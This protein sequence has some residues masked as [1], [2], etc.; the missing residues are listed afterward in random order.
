MQDPITH[1]T[2][3]EPVDIPDKSGIDEKIVSIT[4]KVESEVPVETTKQVESSEE[5]PKGDKPQ[6]QLTET[7]WQSTADKRLAEKIKVEL[8][9][10]RLK[11]ELNSFKNPPQPKTEPMQEPIEPTM[12]QEY[13]PLDQFTKG[14]SSYEYNLR[15]NQYMKDITKYNKTLATELKTQL[16]QTATVNQASQAK[17]N[18]ISQ[19]TSRGVTPEKANQVHEWATK[20]FTPEGF[21]PERVMNLYELETGQPNATNQL[22]STQMDQ[23]T[24]KAKQVLPPGIIPTDAAKKVD[25]NDE[26]NSQFKKS[27]SRSI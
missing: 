13:D 8:E 12:P 7:F 26:F 2:L 25:P 19:Y 27:E 10:E 4:Q 18:A 3:F 22:K 15:F 23:R 9:N 17:A 6:E 1:D 16:E 14:T 11:N 20:F 24:E 21:T 5:L